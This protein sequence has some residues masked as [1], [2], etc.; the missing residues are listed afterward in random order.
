[1]KYLPFVLVVLVCAQAATAADLSPANWE[2]SLREKAERQEAKSWAPPNA[3]TFHTKGG[4]I[5]ATVSPIAVEAGLE[6]LRR[7]GNA[8]DA[9]TTIAL[10]QVT[11]QL[12][13]VVSYAGI[14]TALYYDAK[15]GK[16]FSLDGGYNSYRGESDPQSIPA[17]DL[18]L[19]T[20][21]P[22]PAPAKD[23]GRQTLV[24]GF[25]AS[26]EALHARFGRLLFADLFSPA[27]WYAENGVIVSPALAYFFQVRQ[28]YLSRTSAGRQFL[29]QAGAELPKTGDVFRQPELA[30][31]LRAIAGDGARFMYTGDWANAFVTAVQRD[32]GKATLA[33]LADYRP[34]WSE[35]WHTT[36]FGHEI[37]VG[38][39]P[40]LSVYKLL[41]AVD[42]ADAMGIDKR[43]S[44]WTDPQTFLDLSRISEVTSSNPVLLPQTAARLQ[45]NG[46]DISP[47]GQRTQAFARAL[48]GLLPEL[49]G[50]SPDNDPHH[51]NSIVVIDKDGNIAVVTHSINTVIWGDS[52]IVVGGIPIPDSAGF[53]QA[54]MATIEP[55]S[56]LPNEIA[57]T[58]VLNERRRP[59]LATASIGSALLPETLRMLVS[60][61]GQHRDLMAV[62]AAPPLLISVDPKSY[63]RPLA[64][65]PMSVP[66]GAYDTAFLDKLKTMGTTVVEVPAPVVAGIRGTLAL[67]AI[68]P[69]TRI[70]TTPEV[71]GVMVFG[72]AE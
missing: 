25:M 69:K 29:H 56:R 20:G 31:T 10:T 46:V 71:P 16:I 61:I 68:D 54:R 34:T 32:G 36:A 38:G 42:V 3:R 59:V 8:A 35:P 43:N 12:G 44:Y 72:G 19:L 33:D 1:M 26:I 63:A 7:G 5:S 66:A 4:M 40:N 37:Y 47:E 24:P 41:T 70:R 65:R 22:A 11:T 27:I 30:S 18:S 28:K 67:V 9:A 45:A 55:G 62:A 57:D 52:G 49:Y 6:T 53:Q 23:I 15:T 2:K 64:Q 13:S 17:N 39:P 14:M 60:V 21:G 58:I 48:A 51:S 50:A